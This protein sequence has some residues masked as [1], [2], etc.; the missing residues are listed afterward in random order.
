MSFELFDQPRLE[1]VVSRIRGVGVGVTVD[2]AAIW[3]CRS[4]ISSTPAVLA[5]ALPLVP[6]P[7]R[8]APPE[9]PPAPVVPSAPPALAAGIAAD[10][11]TS[12][13]Q[14]AAP[15][16]RLR[17]PWQSSSRAAVPPV[18]VPPAAVT[19]LA[20]PAL[21]PAAPVLLPA[22]GKPPLEDGVEPQAA[23]PAT[24]KHDSDKTKA[25]RCIES[26]ENL[27]GCGG[28]E[29]GWP[30][31]RPARARRSPVMSRGAP[32]DRAKILRRRQL[33]IRGRG[34]RVFS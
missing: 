31:G 21:L 19:A 7:L 28:R 32:S 14:F 17:Q 27:G 18:E 15:L 24:A 4:E 1:A 26:P 20:T 2:A 23:T 12:R 3:D 16:R 8:L 5:P 30:L 22:P 33:R 6:A 34:A 25:E 29:P 11:P 13:W 10:L 9:L